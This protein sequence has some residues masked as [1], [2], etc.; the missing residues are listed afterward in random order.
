MSTPTTKQEMRRAVLARRTERSVAERQLVADALAAHVVALPEVVR[1]RTIACYLS[2][3]TEPGT[4][5][6]IEALLARGANVLAP[7]ARDGRMAWAVLHPSSE[8][9]AGPQ[10]VLEPAGPADGDITGAGLLLVPGLAVD[11]AGRR[12]G[13]GGG[14][15]DRLLASLDT[16][17]CVLLYGDE[18]LPRVPVEPHDERVD[19]V[20]TELGVSHLGLL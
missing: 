5:P 2:S 13:R 7:Q 17:S 11:A 12:L 8:Y 9:V 1:A 10:G 18:V 20:A 16:P 15:Y 4:A 3:P 14:Y 19:M 6:L